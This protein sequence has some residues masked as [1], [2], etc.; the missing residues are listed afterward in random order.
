MKRI[1]QMSNEI[2]YNKYLFLCIVISSILIQLNFDILLSIFYFKINNCFTFLFKWNTGINPNINGIPEIQ[3][4]ITD[5][6][7]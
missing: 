3:D 5:N 1:D 2:F 7:L 6:Y 4:G